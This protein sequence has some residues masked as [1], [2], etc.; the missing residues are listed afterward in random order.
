MKLAGGDAAPA[1]VAAVDAMI[2]SDVLVGADEAAELA[3]K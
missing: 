1:V 3:K 2:D